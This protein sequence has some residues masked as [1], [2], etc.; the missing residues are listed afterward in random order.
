[1]SSAA[2]LGALGFWIFITAI[3]VGGMWYDARRKESQQE[4]LR[5]IV[6]SGQ[7]VDP[8]VI[9]RVIGV[10]E[11]EKLARDLKVGAYVVLPLS[12]GMALM[13]VFMGMIAPEPRA[14]LFG[15]AILMAFIGT[16]LL[17]AAKMVERHYEGPRS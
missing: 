9:D 12:P 16:G 6:E 4:T 15:V 5:R 17:M 2:G 10:G 1:M 3:I 11:S 7:E 14:A 13:A 8:A